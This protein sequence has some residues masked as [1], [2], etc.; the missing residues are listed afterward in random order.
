MSTT[1]DSLIS[2]ISQH[3]SGCPDPTISTAIVTALIELCTKSHAWVQES[4][5]TTY[6]ALTTSLAVPV[7]GNGLVEA[8]NNVYCN[9]IEVY[10]KTQADLALMFQ[11]WKIVTG[12]PT[13]YFI[14]NGML[15]LVPTPIA[16]VVVQMGVV[17]KPS[18]SETIVDD[19]FYN[20]YWQTIV[21]GAL[22]YLMIL[23][24]REWSDSTLAA[25]HKSEFYTG[26][27]TAKI[28]VF[29]NNTVTSNRVS[30][31]RLG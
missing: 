16:D 8:V 9:G 12:T 5:D 30:G 19:W 14:D 22:Y 11:D 25:D 15:R 27:D 26:I 20:K 3:V 6:P 13:H 18:R 10:V 21:H 29:K 17:L 28:N 24:K 23:P 31:R 1:L 2:D 4:A 7:V